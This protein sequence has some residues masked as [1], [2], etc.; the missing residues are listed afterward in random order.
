MSEDNTIEV[1]IR[2]R[3]L[4]KIIKGN[5]NE[6][7]SEIISFLSE[8]FPKL[9]LISKLTLTI[10]EERLLD[11]CSNIMKVTPEGVVITVPTENLTDRELILLH[12]LKTHIGYI[13][14]SIDTERA[15]IG[16]L[17]AY[18]RKPAGTIAGRISEMCTEG[19]VER[20]GKGEY[21]ITTYGLD[22]FIKNIFPK[23]SP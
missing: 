2:Y 11:T 19:L 14:K 15:M 18:T 22:Y 23:I 3:D 6:V 16:D 7:I 12:L 4:E 20:I 9:N 21:K 8:Q 17:I 5:Q 13:T 1:R 10:D